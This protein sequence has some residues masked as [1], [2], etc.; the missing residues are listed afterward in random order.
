M[1]LTAHLAIMCLI[2]VLD[3]T[4]SLEGS[5]MMGDGRIFLK[6]PRKASITKDLSNEPDPSRWTVPLSKI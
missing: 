4:E 5:H 6:N 3:G 1:R 2:T